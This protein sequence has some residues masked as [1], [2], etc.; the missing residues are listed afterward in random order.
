MTAKKLSQRPVDLI[1]RLES[2]LGPLGMPDKFWLPRVEELA[3]GGFVD[4]EMLVQ[5]IISLK[6]YSQSDN[7]SIYR[8]FKRVVDIVLCIACSVLLIPIF[9]ILALAIK[10][11]S[12]GPVLF[13]QVRIG[14]LGRPFKIIKFRT[15][16]E[17]SAATIGEFRSDTL[18]PYFK[19]NHDP[20]ITR[21]GKFLRRW[22]LDE[23]P[24]FINVLLGDMTLI[25][26]R[27]L[28]VY[29]VAGIPLE[30]IDRFSVRPGLTGLW[31]VLAR[32]SSDGIKNLMI[33]KE[34]AI[35]FNLAM[36]LKILVKTPWVVISGIGAR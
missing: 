9:L 8:A 11:D 32:G 27:P 24:Q 10:L 35:N 1:G 29:D 25:G 3:R 28:P 14:F 16:H 33:D 4:E 20:R 5:T 36:D 22:S 34:Y 17:D 21:V 18:G 13:F 6:L 12:P 30:L 7:R 31:Q 15:M 2:R 26:P 19:I 23:L